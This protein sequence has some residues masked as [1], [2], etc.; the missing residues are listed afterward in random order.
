MLRQCHN[1]LDH[2]RGCI[3]AYIYC[4]KAAR[5]LERHLHFVA[6]WLRLDSE[7]GLLVENASLQSKQSQ[8]LLFMFLTCFFREALHFQIGLTLLF[9]LSFNLL[10]LPVFLVKTLVLAGNCGNVEFSSRCLLF[11]ARDLNLGVVVVELRDDLVKCLFELIQMP[12]H[13]K[14]FLFCLF[15]AQKRIFTHD[16]VSAALL[17]LR[18][19]FSVLKLRSHCSDPLL[20]DRQ[21]VEDPI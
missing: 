9:S 3:P 16:K 18:Q 1:Q 21:L 8:V 12:T 10:T 19:G 5:S 13:G 6:P 17:L 20:W 4:S 14:M 7:D 15:T 2:P 11:T